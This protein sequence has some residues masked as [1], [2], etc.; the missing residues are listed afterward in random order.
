MGVGLGLGFYGIGYQ[1]GNLGDSCV[2]GSSITESD[3]GFPI[4]GAP[5]ECCWVT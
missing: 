5:G 2:V 1:D 4:D 3:G